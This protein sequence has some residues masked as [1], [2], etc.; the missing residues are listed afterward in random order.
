MINAP[1]FRVQ[2]SEMANDREDEDPIDEA[3]EEQRQVDNELLE[4]EVREG[5]LEAGLTKEEIDQQLIDLKK[6]Q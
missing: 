5:M 4:D 3:A 1:K 2:E 6:R